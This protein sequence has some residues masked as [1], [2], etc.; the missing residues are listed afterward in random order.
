MECIFCGSK[1]N[2][3]ISKKVR[4]SNKNKVIQCKTCNHVQLN[5]IPSREDDERFYDNDLQEKNNRS[6][7]N[8]LK[9]HRKRSLKDIKRRVKLISKIC[10]TSDQLLEIG[11]GYGF[12]L[13]EMR[14]SGF[15][16]TGI[17]VSKERRSIS[18]K[19]TKS[20]IMNINLMDEN[21]KIG[22]FDSIMFFHVLE[23]ISDSI[24][25]LKNL[26]KIQ[27]KK[28]KIII[29]VPNHKDFQNEL[30]PYYKQWNFHL[31]IDIHY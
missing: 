11:S 5:P 16:I 4:D 26:K 6:Y 19:V 12:F 29:E 13:E 9:D 3:I 23:H 1:S 24:S 21:I 7:S 25:F 28:G 10:K 14:K 27:K 30:N 31:S 15:N 8:S 18:K 22:K 20:K 17:E 2:K